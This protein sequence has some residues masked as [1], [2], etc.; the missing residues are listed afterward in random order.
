MWMQP[1]HAGAYFAAA[2]CYA[3]TGQAAA[4]IQG[5]ERYLQFDPTSEW[6]AKARAEIARL[7][8]SGR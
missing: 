3:K 5:Y 7:R 2:D 6:A 8:A 1:N 4:A